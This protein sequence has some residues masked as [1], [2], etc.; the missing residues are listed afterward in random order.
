[1]D[2]IFLVVVIAGLALFDLAALHW[3]FDSTDPPDSPE[4]ERRRT[5]HGRRVGRPNE[6]GG[7]SEAS[8]PCP[9]LPRR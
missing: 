5:W 9:P 3:G 4:W 1:M 6:G 2:T 8:P 7:R